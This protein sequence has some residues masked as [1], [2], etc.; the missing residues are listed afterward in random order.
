M[1]WKVNCF[2]KSDRG[3]SS[4][5]QLSIGE[6]WR[7]DGNWLWKINGIFETF[8]F[9]LNGLLGFIALIWK[10]LKFEI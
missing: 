7:M 9:R 10:I 6:Y 2:L 8:E 1:R 5:K 3:K 4:R